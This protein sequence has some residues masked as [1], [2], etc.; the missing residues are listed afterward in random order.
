MK[1]DAPF[2]NFH[3]IT[4]TWA[5]PFGQNRINTVVWSLSYDNSRMI[6]LTYYMITPIYF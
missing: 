4:P 1:K 3:M 6:N 2:D 5:Q